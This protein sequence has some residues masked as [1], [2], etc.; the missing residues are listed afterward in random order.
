[1]GVR[2]FWGRLILVGV[3][4]VGSF[5]IFLTLSRGAIVALAVSLLFVGFRT[6][7]W[8]ATVGL[9]VVLTSPLWVPQQVKDRMMSTQVE[10]EGTD[11][12]ALEGSAELRVQTWQAVLRVVQD[13]PIDGVGFTGLGYVLPDTG[14]DLGVEVKDSAHNTYLRMLGELGIFGLG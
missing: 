2:S 5:A 10:V 8:M 13:H 9:L 14:E 4:A 11:E 3:V 1:V 6:S 12:V 7:K